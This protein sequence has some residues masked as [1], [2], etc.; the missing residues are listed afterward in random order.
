MTNIKMNLADLPKE[1]REKHFYGKVVGDVEA[2]EES[3]M[4][5]FTSVPPEVSAYFQALLKYDAEGR[6]N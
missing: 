3:R 4:V 2:D 1:I 6:G 5:R